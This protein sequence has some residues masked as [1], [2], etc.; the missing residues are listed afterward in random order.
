MK[1]SL[2]IFSLAVCLCMSGIAYGLSFERPI[3]GGAID[4]ADPVDP[5]VA[6]EAAQA[7]VPKLLGEAG[8]VVDQLL[9]GADLDALLRETAAVGSPDGLVRALLTRAFDLANLDEATLCGFKNAFEHWII[10][11]GLRELVE[12]FGL[13][14]DGIHGMCRMIRT[15]NGELA[16]AE[17][18]AFERKGIEAKLKVLKE[19]FCIGTKRDRYFGSISQARNCITHRQGVI[20]P[21]DL[22]GKGY[23]AEVVSKVLINRGIWY[24]V[25]MGPFGDQREAHKKMAAIKR[26]EK[27]EPII[28]SER[29]QEGP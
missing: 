20:G 25:R 3:D 1:S 23:R 17:V 9:Q 14:L 29:R 7:L 28:Q 12:S 4:L 2:I 13:F 6:F 27:L 15:V 26:S 5:N 24:R 16:E 8:V 22:R 21:E 11:N 10:A 18:R 19:R